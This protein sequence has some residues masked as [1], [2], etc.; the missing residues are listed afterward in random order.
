MKK[1]IIQNDN[2]TRD[3]FYLKI[4]EFFLKKKNF[5][6]YISDVNTL[7]V[8]LRRI[9]P[10]AVLASRLDNDIIQKIKHLTNI[11]IIA[12]E[13]GRTTKESSLPVYFG[14]GLSTLKSKNFNWVKRVYCWNKN[15]KKWLIGSKKFQNK[16]SFVSGNPKIDI[17]NTQEF[18][19]ETKIRKKKNFT[20]GVAFSSHSTSSYK[21]KLWT[22]HQS[23]FYIKN[24]PY[25]ILKKGGYHEDMVWRDYGLLRIFM[26]SIRELLEKT[27]Y[28]FL[29]KVG[30]FENIE[31]FKFLEK[32]YPKRIKICNVKLSTHAFIKKIDI[33][34]TGV[35]TIGIE[36]LINKKPVFSLNGFFDQKRLYDHIDL[37]KSGYTSYVKLYYHIKNNKDLIDKI[38]LVRNKSLNFSS[39]N[40]KVTN[41][42]LESIYFNYNK[43]FMASNLIAED[44]SAIVK[45]SKT[46]K[47]KDAWKKKLKMRYEIPYFF[48]LILIRIRDLIYA[49]KSGAFK[50]YL[51]FFSSKNSD[52]DKEI[53]KYFS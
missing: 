44:I 43:K 50:N 27:N 53:K 38:K 19:K 14:S 7:K 28:N 41:R 22:P 47:N 15:V 40:E 17:Y 33:L 2:G 10:D 21:G 49:L 32:N 42:E 35:S 39:K 51:N 16:Q 8:N 24:H 18:K 20:I 3:L 11:F 4:I 31:Y 34:L 36:A 5:Q 37:K 29:I 46:I 52:L 25:A 1:I 12:G 9:K 48:A 26:N 45:K 23:Y 6:T 13:G 30:P